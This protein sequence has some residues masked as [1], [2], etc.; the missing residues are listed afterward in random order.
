[1][2]EICNETSPNNIVTDRDDR[3]PPC[4]LLRHLRRQ[5]AKCGD[6][7]DFSADQLCSEF[8]KLSNS[9]FSIT[10]FNCYGLTFDVT[11]LTKRKSKG[12][13]TRCNRGHRS[14]PEY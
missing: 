7:I 3:N 1:M 6:D 9:F 8:G 2:R 5:I 4:R 11:E 10:K 14:R 12:F 13:H